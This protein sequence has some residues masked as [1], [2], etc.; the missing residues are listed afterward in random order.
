VPP[1]DDLL[2]WLSDA[3]RA[4]V[5]TGRYEVLLL[6]ADFEGR[7]QTV[8]AEALPPQS[9]LDHFLSGVHCYQHAALGQAVHSLESALRLQPDHFW[10]RF[11]LAA[12]QLRLQNWLAAE[13][14]LSVCQWQRPAF[15]WTRL[16]RGLAQVEL[17]Q[18]DAAEETLHQAQAALEDNPEAPTGPAVVL[19]AQARAVLS[20]YRGVLAYRQRRLPQA[21][22]H[23]REAIGQ[24]PT[25][26]QA[27]A[28][29]LRASVEQ[30]RLD[31]A[32]AWFPR[33]A[34]LHPPAV[35]V[36]DY[37]TLRARHLCRQQR[38]AEAVRACN[39][40]VALRADHAEAFA[41]L[42]QAL[43]ELQ[44]YVHA[45]ESFDRYLDLRGPPLADVYRGRGQ[46]R[47]KLGRFLDAGDDYTQALQGTIDPQRVAALVGLAG[48]TGLR[49]AQAELRAHR[50]WAWFF[51]NAFELALRDFNQAG[52]LLPPNGDTCAGRGLCQVM[53]GRYAEAVAD[54]RQA[55]R[56][57]VPTPEMTF[58]VACIFSLAAGKVRADAAQPKR[59]DLEA[60]YRTQAIALIHSAL[61]LVPDEKRAVFWE[62]KMRHDQALDPIRGSAEFVQLEKDH[63]LPPQGRAGAR[64]R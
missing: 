25:L 11:F 64:Q 15:P 37:H 19:S 3:Q 38:H 39:A 47:M 53:L 51:G 5:A 59:R 18:F 36:A 34:A 35:V 44:D 56:L 58:N 61:G 10:S 55:L 40:A 52:R 41:V 49:A 21:A 4:E 46:A 63:A 16:L 17:A 43:L 27:H 54:A 1:R 32:G 9:A 57:G 20:F 8:R 7:R 12:T 31:E 14:T 26:Y 60:Q 6:R 62:T 42:G 45:A 50:G 23:F 22:E 33:L 2:T 29:L 24:Q 48:T 28:G 13:A 30:G